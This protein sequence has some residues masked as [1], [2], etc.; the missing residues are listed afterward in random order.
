MRLQ[1]PGAP[2]AGAPAMAGAI[3]TDKE[4]YVCA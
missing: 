2:T 1:L 3:E 4:A